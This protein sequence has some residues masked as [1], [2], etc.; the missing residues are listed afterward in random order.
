A[1]RVVLLRVAA[2]ARL[3]A[4]VRG[5]GRTGGGR[6]AE[7]RRNGIPREGADRASHDRA[8]GK[9]PRGA[10][11][12]AGTMGH[13]ALPRIPKLTYGQSRHGPAGSAPTSAVGRAS[14][15]ANF[16]NAARYRRSWA[17]AFLVS[18]LCETR[19]SRPQ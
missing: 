5:G 10:V 12:P 16:R 3:C 14:P 1:P 7:R 18:S 4:D 9:P 11:E 8:G 6:G 15:R 17:C 2:G 13:S 19:R